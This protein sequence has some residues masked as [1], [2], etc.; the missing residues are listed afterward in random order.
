M[1]G[2]P[3]TT[4]RGTQENHI[5][6]RYWRMKKLKL[7]KLP[8]FILLSNYA[9]STAQSATSGRVDVLKYD[10]YL[11]PHFSNNYI[12]GSVSIEFSK[13]PKTDKVV[14]NSGE[15][16]VTDIEGEHVTDYIQKDKKTIISLAKNDNKIH[17]IK[18][19]YHGNPTKGLVFFDNPQK[20]YSVY[21]TSEWMICNT[22]PNDRATLELDILVPKGL[23]CVASGTLKDTIETDNKIK[24]SFTQDYATPAYTYGFT[25]GTFNKSQ[26]NH[27]GTLLKCYSDIHTPEEIEKIFQFTEDMMSFF[28]DKSGIPYPQ[29]T[30]SQ[31]LIGTHFQE[32]SG[33]AILKESYGSL[34]LRDS[35]ETNLISHELA[36]QWWGNMITC[37][38]WN[39]F[40][41]NEGFATFM[42]AAYNEHLFGNKKYQEDIDAYF[43]VYKKI[44]SKGV[45]KPLVFDN[46][47]NPS[48]DDRN[49]VY[50]K[51]A[52]VLHLLRTELGDEPFWDGIKY[53][54]QTYY[55]KS[56]T[57]RDFQSAMEKSTNRSL[58]SFFNEW[59]Y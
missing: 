19:S 47:S 56:V 37:K 8:F 5:K 10:V 49:L 12:E 24:Y 58:Q 51:G 14:F 32:M 36:H 2:R 35:T 42:S 54:S 11:E 9:L 23:T 21:F 27:K 18:L 44:K 17:E 20:L 28:E 7:I 1:S 50:F 41:L 39:H 45:D 29:K 53:F 30:Y 34:V 6:Y 26:N 16:V 46:W 43:G 57:T 59:I 22:S 48:Q 38:S 33:F 55:G 52:Y 3:Q 40:W 4:W 31:V 13:G 25:L 15:L